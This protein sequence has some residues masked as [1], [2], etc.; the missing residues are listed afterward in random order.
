[1]DYEVL[2]LGYN[3]FKQSD[4]TIT[5]LNIYNY[6]SLASVADAYMMKKG[7]YK[8]V[9]KVNGIAREFIQKC[10]VGGWTMCAENKKHIIDRFLDGFDAVSLYPSDMERLGEY[11]Q[12]LLKVLNNLGYK[13]LP[14]VDGYFIEIKI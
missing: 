6:I 8:D 13:F 7:V 1:M 9:Y 14:S 10:M 3:K 2:S 11:L 4:K 12:G 5:G